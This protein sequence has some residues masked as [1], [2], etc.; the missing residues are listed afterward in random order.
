ME[1]K[2]L[3]QT[4]EE[5]HLLEVKDLRTSFFVPAG[6]VKSVDGS[7]FV[8]DKGTLIRRRAR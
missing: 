4:Q 8:V 5:H 2:I 3:E 6:E 1:E 7:S